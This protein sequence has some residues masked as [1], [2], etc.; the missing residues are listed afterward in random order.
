MVWSD[1]VYELFGL[2][3]TVTLTVPFKVV[4]QLTGEIFNA[5]TKIVEVEVKAPV[6]KVIVPPSPNFEVPVWVEPLN[7]E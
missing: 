3:L 5:L 1:N 7:N 2:G 6:V 4:V